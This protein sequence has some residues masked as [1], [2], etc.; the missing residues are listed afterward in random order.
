MESTMWNRVAVPATYKATNL[1]SERSRSLYVGGDDRLIRQAIEH[2]D[3]SRIPEGLTT[4][5][6][7][8]SLTQIIPPFSL[9]YVAM[10]NDYFMHRADAGFVRARLPGIRGILDW[11][12]RHIDSTGMLGVMPYWNYVDWTPRW[13]RGVPPRADAGHSSAISLRWALSMTCAMLVVSE[14]LTRYFPSA[15]VAPSFHF[16]LI[17]AASVPQ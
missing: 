14:V 6:Y 1:P 5:R 8:S 2:F 7:P 12:A 17:P 4:S 15:M 11:Y 16:P 10:V 3:L 9:I 13:D